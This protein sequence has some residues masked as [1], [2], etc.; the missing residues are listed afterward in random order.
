MNRIICMR[1]ISYLLIIL[2][3]SCRQDEIKRS[4]PLVTTDEVTFISSQGAHF[5]ASFTNAA[6]DD[7]IDCGFVWGVDGTLTVENSLHLKLG[8]PTNQSFSVDAKSSLQAKIKYQVRP[9]VRTKDVTV[10]GKVVTFISLGSLAPVMNEFSLKKGRNGDT[11]NITGLYFG[12]SLAD[13]KVIFEST[14][15]RPT[16]IFDPTKLTDTEIKIVV[17]KELTERFTTVKVQVLGNI[18]KGSG[19]FELIQPLITSLGPN[20]VRYLDS[21]TVNYQSNGFALTE[22]V[23]GGVTVPARITPQ[24]VRFYLRV[25]SDPMTV[26]IQSNRLSSEMTFSN[27]TEPPAITGIPASI[28]AGDTIHLTWTYP[29]P[30]SLQAFADTNFSPMTVLNKTNLGMDVVIPSCLRGTYR[31][32]IKASDFSFNSSA[33]TI[34]PPIMLSVSPTQATFGDEIIIT[35]SNFYADKNPGHITIGTSVPIAAISKTQIKAVMPPLPYNMPS[36]KITIDYAPCVSNELATLSIQYKAPV[37]NSVSPTTI[38]TPLQTITITGDNFIP[39]P[40]HNYNG[41]F[42]NGLT[43]T[44]V[45]ATKT[46]MVVSI[47]FTNPNVSINDQT[48]IAVSVA[49][50][51][52]GGPLLNIDYHG[53]WT[54]LPDPTVSSRFEPVAF[55]VGGKG[56]VGLGYFSILLNDLWEY[57]PATNQWTAMPDFPGEPRYGMACFT[58]SGK[59]Y[60]GLGYNLSY[61]GGPKYYKDFWEFN[62][63]TKQWAAVASLPGAARSSA[64]TFST[65]S[66]GFAGGGAD[67]NGAALADFYQFNPASGNW[68]QVADVPVSN[69]WEFVTFNNKG[70]IYQGP[71][72]TTTI[73]KGAIFDI[74]TKQ[75]SADNAIPDLPP[76]YPNLMSLPNK[77][78]IAGV[79][80]NPETKSKAPVFL[81]YPGSH[82]LTGFVINGI[83]Y[84]LYYNPSPGLKF[85]LVSFDPTK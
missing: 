3:F 26:R 58:A 35:G 64:V 33:Y 19:T 54:L 41:V 74:A 73:T 63:S 20:K 5:S 23:V 9:Y 15:N 13:A 31:I 65:A 71:V 60:L 79:S 4:Y 81:P 48:P 57:D 47:N 1:R 77:T 11:L 84:E 43:C 14:T 59:A 10:Y 42:V 85:K 30:T 53:M 69:I 51:S 32:G 66:L 39:S 46:Q 72:S 17:P 83:G 18:A 75:W 44:V 38:N 25:P 24:Y 82:A 49:G 34:N 29:L 76:S 62:P 22:V 36:G 68:T 2:L 16:L 61:P 27:F 21:I 8:K 7:I 67:L 12:Q 55:G 6:P 56:Y 52:V 50:Q 45:S 70:Y 80:Y 40:Y 78:I 28:A 37:I